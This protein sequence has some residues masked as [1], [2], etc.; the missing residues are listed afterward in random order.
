MHLSGRIVTDTLLR[1]TRKSN[2]PSK[3]SF[4]FDLAPDGGYLAGL[5]TKPAGG[6]L[7][8]LFNL[9]FRERGMFLWPDPKAYAFPGVTWHPAL[10]C[11]DFPHSGASAHVQST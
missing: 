3:L 4:L 2:E 1:S 8:H 10:W 11:T 9:T 7:H 5:V 6:L